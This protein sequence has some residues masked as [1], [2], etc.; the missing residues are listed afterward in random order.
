V[1]GS[2]VR[3]WIS[4]WN[5][6]RLVKVVVVAT[7]GDDISGIN[8]LLIGNA[9]VSTAGQDL[10]A[11]QLALAKLGVDP[12]HIYTDRGLTGVNRERPGLRI[13]LASCRN[14][15]TLMV[16]KLDRLAQSLRNASDIVDV[17]TLKA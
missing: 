9:R 13:A 6:R 11:Q 7:I 14:G 3:K 2:D 5:L 12:G 10:T 8:E 4:R 1:S 15:D 16:A 17:L